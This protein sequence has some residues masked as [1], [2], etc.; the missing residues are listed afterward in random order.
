M[1]PG[2]L[3]A[4]CL[5]GL[6][7]EIHFSTIYTADL[8]N[9]L[10]TAAKLHSHTVRLTSVTPVGTKAE[11]VPDGCGVQGLWPRGPLL[12]CRLPRSSGEKE[13]RPQ[14]TPTGS[15]TPARKRWAY[16]FPWPWGNHFSS[17]WFLGLHDGGV[18][19]LSSSNAIRS[20]WYG[21]WESF[22]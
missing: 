7:Q 17:S 1:A 19:M 13:L 3:A 5:F 8:R 11:E 2:Q 15:S 10:I 14:V 6:E 4:T 16:I 21:V 18:I 12:P 9:K 22:V 20:K